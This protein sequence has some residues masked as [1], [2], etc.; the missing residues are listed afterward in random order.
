MRRHDLAWVRPGAAVRFLCGALDEALS[1]QVAAWIAVGRPLVVA[2]QLAGGSEALLGLT[3]PAAEGRRRVGC[4]VERADLLQV[5][6]P[7]AI[8]KC[9][10]RLADDVAAPLAAL[11][12][13]LAAAG[14]SAGVY[15]SLAWEALSGEGYRHP[16]SDVDLICDVASIAQAEACLR[17]LADGA[18][19]LPCGL[20]G[21]I[22]FPDGC[23]VAWR[24][25][26]SAWGKANARVLV[27]GGVDVG[28][29][30]LSVVLEQFEEDALHV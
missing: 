16:E 5:R 29:L 14:V 22:R 21:E 12:E 26:A 9:L 7:L 27:K 2:R 15:G 3:L 6:R 13:R 18:A 30:P 25:L 8:A 17:L 19:A 11:A 24:E 28:L 4:L 23:A 10:H 20:D 1:A